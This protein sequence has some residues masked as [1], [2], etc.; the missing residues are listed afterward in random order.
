MGCDVNPKNKFHTH[1][2]SIHAPQW[3]ATPVHMPLNSIDS[4]FQSTHPSG[5]R[6]AYADT[7]DVAETISIHAPQW[8]ATRP[9]TNGTCSNGSIS[10]HAPQWGATWCV[11]C[12]RP[13]TVHFN[14][15]TPVGCD[16]IASLK[17]AQSIWI[18]IHAPQWG[19]T[20]SISNAIRQNMYFN[21]RTPVGCDLRQLDA[22]RRQAISIHAPQWGA[23]YYCDSR[24]SYV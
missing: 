3:G 10:I 15:R 17:E 19:A 24:M 12:R 6:P 22:E 16:E 18:S 8:G 23:T 13:A 5:V 21:P 2:I 4:L 14:P 20:S 1:C 7:H 9:T 11:R